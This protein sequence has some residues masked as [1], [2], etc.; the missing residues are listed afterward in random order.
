M[1]DETPPMVA[2]DPPPAGD[3][4]PANPPAAVVETKYELKL[5]TDATLDAAVIER[6]VAFARERKLSNEQA[7]AV[8]DQLNTEAT[9]LKGALLPAYQPGGAEW[10]KNQQAEITKAVDGWKAETNADVTLGK[11]PEERAANLRSAAGVLDK[12]EAAS[13]EMGKALKTA[14]SSSGIAERREVAHFLLWL[15]KAAGEAQIIT[16]SSG[17]GAR[18]ETEKLYQMYPSMKPA[19]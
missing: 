8:L 12:F 13:P 11:T 16:P 14:L 19:A 6:T 5:P 15:G 10:Q 18:S 1:A 4:P 2:A 3:P 17:E 9:T 7:Q